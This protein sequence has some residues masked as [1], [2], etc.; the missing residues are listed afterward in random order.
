MEILKTPAA[1]AAFSQARRARGERLGLVPTMGYLHDG[2]LALMAEARRQ[3]ETLV[4]SIFVNPIQFNNADDLRRYPRDEAGDL[5]KCREAGVAAVYLPEVE[6]MYAPDFCTGVS[7]ARLGEPLCGRTRP[8]HFVGVT[9]VVSKLFNAVSPQLAVF[10]KKDYQQLA[11]IRRLVR[12]LDYPITIIGH[13]ILRAADGLA[14][15][16][17]NARLSPEARAAAL[18]LPQALVRAQVAF[19]AGERRSATLLRIAQDVLA[20][21]APEVVDYLE[22]V[23]AE[24]L[25]TPGDTLSRPAVLAAAASF[26]GVRLID[27]RELS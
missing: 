4:V 17:R 23:D 1:M 16:S 7:V 5:A 19:T 25:E 13:P 24:T 10:G 3:A 22:L 27:N 9:T 21:G 8:G 12:D 20:Q 26:G 11:I 15:S 14:L 18:S 2:H 6:A